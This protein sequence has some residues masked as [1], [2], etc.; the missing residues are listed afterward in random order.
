[1]R[2]RA[3]LLFALS[4]VPSSALADPTHEIVVARAAV[5]PGTATAGSLTDR[6]QALGLTPRMSLLDGLPLNLAPPDPAD[7]F[8]LDPERVILVEARD[9][10]AAAAALEAL[11]R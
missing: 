8:G 3:L 7:P 1:M 5:T 9:S 11:A 10:S 6:L 2:T 4:L